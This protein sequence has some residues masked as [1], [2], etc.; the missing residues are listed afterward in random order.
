MHG[1]IKL[2]VDSE[3]ET[4]E[5]GQMC[6]LRDAGTSDEENFTMRMRK[7]EAFGNSRQARTQVNQ[8][9]ARINRWGTSMKIVTFHFVA[10]SGSN[11]QVYFLTGPLFH[12]ILPRENIRRRNTNI[13]DLPCI[14]GFLLIVETCPFAFFLFVVQSIRRTVCYSSPVRAFRRLLADQWKFGQHQRTLG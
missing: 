11:F 10:A 6:G 13:K 8:S 1:R 5:V 7:K 14:F 2:R 12:Q 9:I 4:A 3:H